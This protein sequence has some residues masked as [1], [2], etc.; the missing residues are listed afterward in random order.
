MKR[1]KAKSIFTLTLLAITLGFAGLVFS[2]PP[3]SIPWCSGPCSYYGDLNGQ[4]ITWCD[5][6]RENCGLPECHPPGT[7]CFL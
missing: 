5:S 1:I 2:A 7:M 4:C 3:P 6:N